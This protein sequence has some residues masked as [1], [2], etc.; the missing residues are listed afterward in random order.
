MEKVVEWSLINSEFKIMSRNQRKLKDFIILYIYIYKMHNYET[1]VKF[2]LLNL[3]QWVSD[4][5]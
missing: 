4:L 1:I 2:L 5:D 3:E